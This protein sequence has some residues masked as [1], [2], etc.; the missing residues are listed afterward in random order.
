MA[1]RRMLRSTRGIT[2]D[3]HIQ[4][5]DIHDREEAALIEEKLADAVLSD[6][7]VI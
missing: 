7:V 5:E 1:E 2:C 6:D 4:T 3:D